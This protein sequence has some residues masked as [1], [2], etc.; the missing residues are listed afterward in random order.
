MHILLGP[1]S[2]FTQAFEEPSQRSAISFFFFNRHNYA[3][4]MCCSPPSSTAPCFVPGPTNVTLINLSD[5]LSQVT[6]V[7]TATCVT[8][9]IVWLLS[10]HSCDTEVTPRVV[11]AAV[12]CHW[13]QTSCALLHWPYYLAS[14][15]PQPAR[16]RCHTTQRYSCRHWLT[17]RHRDHTHTPTCWKGP[18]IKLIANV[19]KQTCTGVVLFKKNSTVS[20]FLF[21]VFLENVLISKETFS[22]IS[23]WDEYT[24]SIC[25]VYLQ[26]A[27]T[28]THTHT[29]KNPTC[30]ARRF[31]L[32]D[33]FAS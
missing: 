2:I 33:D 26:C 15:G 4:Q 28:H 27:H 8:R 21:F 5:N 30:A 3:N 29:Q 1:N 9:M 7:F 13:Q 25:R 10:L 18:L 22:E 24:V 23:T 17:L 16:H 32:A 31:W 6:P 11:D 20:F 14:I 12:F 19:L